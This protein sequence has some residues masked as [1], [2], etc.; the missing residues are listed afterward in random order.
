MGTS[1]KLGQGK[2]KRMLIP[3]INVIRE[4]GAT[5]LGNVIETTMEIVR[6][7]RRKELGV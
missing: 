4:H 5:L 1:K 7:E 6:T 3:V 2:A